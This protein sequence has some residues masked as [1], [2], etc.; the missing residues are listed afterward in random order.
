MWSFRR[1]A[2]SP[3]GDIVDPAQSGH[4]IRE[5]NRAGGHD[6][7]VL[8]LLA[9]STSRQGPPSVAVHRTFGADRRCR[10]NLHEMAGLLRQRSG[11]SS[12]LAYG[13]ECCH[14]VRILLD[15]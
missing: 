5:T 12:R 4:D 11:V 10:P 2:A 9:R 1:L 13:I 7:R 6:D 14:V 15:Y 8:N 3:L